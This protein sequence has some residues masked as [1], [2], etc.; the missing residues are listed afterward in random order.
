MSRNHEIHTLYVTQEFDACLAAIEE[1]M[2]ASQGAGRAAAR[3]Q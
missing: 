2:E 3:A 1:V